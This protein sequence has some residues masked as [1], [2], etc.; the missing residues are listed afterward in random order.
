MD[1][2]ISSFDGYEGG[3]PA[4]PEFGFRRLP[5]EQDLAQL[6]DLSPQLTD[7]A[8]RLRAFRYIDEDWV[9]RWGYDEN[10]NEELFYLDNHEEIDVFWDIEKD[11]MML[12]GDKALLNRKMSQ[13][14]G[15]L[16]SDLKLDPV[17]FDYDFFLW[18]LYK[19]YEGQTL[20]AGSNLRI[21][22]MTRGETVESAEN[23]D[24]RIKVEGKDDILKSVVMIVP[25]LEGEKI[26]GLQGNFILGTK[27]I[28]VKMKFGG[29][30]HVLV[31]GNPMSSWED[32]RQMGTSVAFLSELIKLYRLWEDLDS[33]NKYPPP[34]F[35]DDLRDS[36]N[37][38]GWKLRFD[39]K[40]VKQEYARKRTDPDEASDEKAEAQV[41]E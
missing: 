33:D 2:I 35:F 17:E 12:L 24:S 22:K 4:E 8:E 13:I 31:T 10:A 18:L 27:Q 19:E 40:E 25:V 30:V 29:K 26:Q 23:R 3:K 37:D 1:E 41:G 39:P 5:I 21:R 34:S 11:A 28:E 16:S 6:D 15:A 32:A 9:E 14:R 38:E 20:D 36:A 7:L